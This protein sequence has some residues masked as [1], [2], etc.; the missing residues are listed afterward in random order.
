MGEPKLNGKSGD[1]ATVCLLAGY[2]VPAPQIG[3]KL[4]TPNPAFKG[5]TPLQGKRHAKRLAGIY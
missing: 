3:R 5:S 1:T 2:V 4:D